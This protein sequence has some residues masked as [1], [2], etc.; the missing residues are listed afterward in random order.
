MVFPLG[1]ALFGG[2]GGIIY[3]PPPSLA[4]VPVLTTM[5]QVG[6]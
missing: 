2:I 4:R 1:G 5:Q 6:P 3:L